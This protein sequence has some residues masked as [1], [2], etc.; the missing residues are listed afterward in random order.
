LQIKEDA[1]GVHPRIQNREKVLLLHGMRF[2]RLYL[3]AYPQT[4]QENARPHP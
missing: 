4:S 1:V 2:Y 3:S